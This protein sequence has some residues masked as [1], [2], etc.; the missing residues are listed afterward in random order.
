M[1]TVKVKLVYSRKRT[2]GSEKNTLNPIKLSQRNVLKSYSV[3][4]DVFDF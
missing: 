4:R 2:E 1:L 3:N